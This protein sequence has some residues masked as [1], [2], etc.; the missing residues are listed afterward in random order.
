MRLLVMVMVCLIAAPLSS[1]SEEAYYS[2]AAGVL[3][4]LKERLQKKYRANGN[5]VDVH[6][7]IADIALPEE[8]RGSYFEA[9]Q[10]SLRFDQE[11]RDIAFVQFTSKTKPYPRDW[12]I[13][14][15]LRTEESDFT[16]I[17]ETWWTRNEEAVF[18]SGLGL[19]FAVLLA[20]G[21]LT[22]RN[23]W[24]SMRPPK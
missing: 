4:A 12:F 24:F 18:W 11:D 2:E 23:K 14:V 9:S 8:L 6:W 16:Y 13:R 17:G 19:S 22:T 10:Y 15:N 5:R 21:W 7:T 1:R 3:M 20:G